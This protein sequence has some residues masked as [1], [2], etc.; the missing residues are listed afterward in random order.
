M[1]IQSLAKL[2]RR[3]RIPLFCLLLAVIIIGSIVAYPLLTSYSEKE[4]VG[5]EGILRLWHIDT[6]EGGQGSR[7]SFLNRVARRYEK[8]AQGRLILVTNHTIES[9]ETAIREGYIP[10]MISY[11]T[12]A[13]FVA[14]LACPLNGLKFSP[15]AIGGVTYA[16]PWCRGGYMLFTA[17]GDFTDISADNTVISKGRGAFP[18]IAAV[19]SGLCGE[20]TEEESVKAY[21]DFINGK[22]KYL[23]GTQRDV[24]RLQSRNFAFQTKPV[25]EF[26]DLYQYISVCTSE[27]DKVSACTE[28]IDYL[29][30]EEVQTSL[31]QIGMMS[32]NYK[33]Y[34]SEAPS[35]AAAEQIVPQKSIGAFLSGDAMSEMEKFAEAALCGDAASAKKLENFLL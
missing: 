14:D 11:G 23:L 34:N 16:Y 24:Y 13:G 26:S 19:S 15:G 32:I 9:A 8:S 2:F 31:T 17:E 21:V 18:A 20:Y 28:F 3:I 22:Y 4:A 6:F 5:Y 30:S 7:C 27:S 33:I 1:K 12:G 10:D 29:L 35:M 25:E